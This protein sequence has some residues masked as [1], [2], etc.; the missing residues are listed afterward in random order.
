MKKKIAI[1]LCLTLLVS[2]FAVNGTVSYLQDKES[3]TNVFTVG[4]IDVTLTEDQWD[5]TDESQERYPGDI[6]YKDPT[7]KAVDGDVY[8]RVKVELLQSGTSTAVSDAAAAL[9]WNTIYYEA[10]AT[11]FIEP[12][13]GTGSTTLTAA[14]IAALVPSVPH[15]NT[16]AFTEAPTASSANVK[17]YT[18]TNGTANPAVLAQNSTAKLFSTIVIPADYSNANFTTMGNYDIKIT[19]EAIQAANIETMSAAAA[20]SAAYP[21]A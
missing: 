10:A 16:G 20:L 18:Y 4:N 3:K 6:K 12:V 11:Q 21:V 7:V 13:S 19:V 1:V 9:I 17:Y 14:Q 2:I 15:Y 5:S 8:L